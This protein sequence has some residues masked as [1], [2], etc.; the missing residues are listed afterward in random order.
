MNKTYVLSKSCSKYLYNLLIYYGKETQLILT[1]FNHTIN[2]VLSLMDPLAGRGYDL[3]PDRFSTS[4]LLARQLL[5][6]KTT[7]TG[8][9]LGNRK[10]MPAAATKSKQKK[11]DVNTYS[12]EK[13]ILTQWTDKRTIT[14]LTTKHTNSMISVSSQ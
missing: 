13:M 6:V 5:L 11:G 8:T 12:N 9:M 2:V 1:P 3:Y 7:L 10:E 4:P 14:T